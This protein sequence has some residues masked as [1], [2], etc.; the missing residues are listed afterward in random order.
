MASGKGKN[1]CSDE[2]ER[3]CRIWLQTTQDSAVG[4]SQ[5]SEGFW[6]KVEASYHLNIPEILPIRSGRSL[7]SRWATIRTD[8]A[9]FNGCV[10]S[11][12]ALNRSGTSEEDM[13]DQAKTLFQSTTSKKKFTLIHCWR[14]L[15]DCEKFKI[16]QQN[17]STPKKGKRQ[18]HPGGSPAVKCGD[19]S[20]ESDEGETVP[21]G[22]PVGSKKFKTEQKN[23]NQV[24]ANY[25]KLAEAA[26]S[27]AIASK[28]KGEAI[29]RAANLQLFTISVDGLDEESKQYILW[30]RRQIILKSG[31]QPA[32]Q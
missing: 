3:L 11:V 7:E 25:A 23:A 12:Q 17:R 24:N 22:R 8:V 28:Q 5:T 16:Q 6:T 19:A 27:L 14:I 18:E 4:T 10:A 20:D 13:L 21:P 1:F 15:K 32:E 2:D 29:E 26:H 9:K 31:M 30:Q